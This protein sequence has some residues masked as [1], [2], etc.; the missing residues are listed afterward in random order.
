M[1]CLATG[2]Q[3][4]PLTNV[5]YL[6]MLCVCFLSCSRI[7]A[8]SILNALISFCP[9]LRLNSVFLSA[10]LA[11]AHFGRVIPCKG[12]KQDILVFHYPDDSWSFIHCVKKTIVQDMT[13]EILFLTLDRHKNMTGLNK[14]MR[15]QTPPLDNWTSKCKTDINKQT[16]NKYNVCRL[17]DGICQ[18]TGRGIT[19]TLCFIFSG[20]VKHATN[21]SALSLSGFDALITKL[22]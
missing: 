5:A 10:Q 1:I 14:G 22:V 6:E 11:A 16:K 13:M 8:F 12:K 21:M 20:P 3:P 18:N 17:L 4:P 9:D 15:F 7:M 19:H 2:Y